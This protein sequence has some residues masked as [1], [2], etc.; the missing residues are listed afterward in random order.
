M[1]GVNRRASTVA[2]G[3]LVGAVLGIAVCVA[4]VLI[5]S[6]QTGNDGDDWGWIDVVRPCLLEATLRDNA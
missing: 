4:I 6:S 1:S 2:L 5:Y 3:L